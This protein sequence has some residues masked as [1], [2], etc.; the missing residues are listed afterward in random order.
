MTITW[1]QRLAPLLLCGLLPWYASASAADCLPYEP[2]AVSLSGLLHRATFPGRPNFENIATGDQPETGFYLT[3]KQPI[4]TRG[5]HD[6]NSTPHDAVREVQL[7]LTE[8]QYAA[9]RPQ[10]GQTVQLKGQLFSSFSGHHHTDVL[11]RVAMP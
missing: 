2:A 8:K 10:L 6:P 9:L 3:L 11:L 5:D 1:R 4:C 7:V